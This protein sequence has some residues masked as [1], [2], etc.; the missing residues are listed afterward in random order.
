M[1]IEEYHS[2][3]K[4]NMFKDAFEPIFV[5]FEPFIDRNHTRHQKERIFEF[6]KRLL[7]ENMIG[8]VSDFGK[9]LTKNKRKLIRSYVPPLST[10]MRNLVNMN[11]SDIQSDLQKATNK[12]KIILLYYLNLSRMVFE[13]LK[14]QALFA[15]GRK[16]KHII[17]CVGMVKL[18]EDDIMVNEEINHIKALTI[19]SD[20][21][22]VIPYNGCT[23]DVFKTALN[24]HKPEAVH[25]AGHGDTKKI[26]FADAPVRYETFKNHIS[27]LEVTSNLYFLNCCDTFSYV[28]KSTLPFSGV[29]VC[30]DGV[31]NAAKACDTSESF[32]R[33]LLFGKSLYDAWKSTEISKNTEGYHLL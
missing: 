10:N 23:F 4:D 25:L 29:T 12:E 17:L 20:S 11:E 15:D 6:R 33:F 27:K 28:N 9:L 30:F 24:R 14:I 1:T 2:M 32:Y 19:S 26:Y 18:K 22:L 7:T 5:F 16:P 13:D 31:L 3:M 21:Y 8:K